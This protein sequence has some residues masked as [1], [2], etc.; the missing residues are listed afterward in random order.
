VRIVD[1]G[2]WR[3]L[4][5]QRDGVMNALPHRGAGK[6]CL[7]GHSSVTLHADSSRPFT[8]DHMHHDDDIVANTSKNQH[9]NDLIEQRRADPK[10]R[11]L[12]KGGLGA[13]SLSFL[14]LG[15]LAGCG[16]DDDAPASVPAPAPPP[17]APPP[18]SVVPPAVAVGQAR[19]ARAPAGAAPPS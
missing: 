11:G 15:A 19:V 2:W 12:L 14:S 7:A 4:L 18:A 13:A 5:C 1:R 8:E 3:A 10:R 6:P 17:P 9:I 16:G